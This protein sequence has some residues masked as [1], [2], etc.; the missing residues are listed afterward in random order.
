MAEKPTRVQLF[1]RRL[2]NHPIIAVLFIVCLIVITAASFT[3]AIDKL[4]YF[5][6]KYIYVPPVQEQLHSPVPPQAVV[7]KVVKKSAVPPASFETDV[8][9]EEPLTGS[10]S[11]AATPVSTYDKPVSVPDTKPPRKVRQSVSIATSA[12]RSETTS[13]RVRSV[14]A[15]LMSL[16]KY[17]NA[18]EIAL[19][20]GSETTRHREQILELLVKRTKLGSLEP[21]DI[22]LV[23]GTETTNNRV[24]CIGIIAP[25]IRP[26]I[27]GEQAAAILGSETTS[28]RVA[29][30][31]PIAP[32]LKRPLSNSDVTRILRGTSTSDRTEAVKV[33]FGK[34]QSID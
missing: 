23:L 13:D 10:V 32:L 12:L 11:S 20:A 34:A 28:H 22:P 31:K 29:C 17:L 4:M 9:K 33:L 3:D 21:E 26:P 18:K 16:P 15:L 19:L 7:S 24:D 25:F 8:H 1:F 2:Q 5:S 30:L 27:T 14:R 6:H